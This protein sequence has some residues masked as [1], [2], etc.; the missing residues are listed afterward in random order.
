MFGW[1]K[2]LFGKADDPEIVALVIIEESP[3]LIEVERVRAAFRTARMSVEPVEERP[4]YV[5]VAKSGWN[6]VVL[7][8]PIRYGAFEGAHFKDN[9]MQSLID[10]HQ[11]F[12]CVECF[13]A[14][15]GV[16]RASAAR[17]ILAKVTNA[18]LDDTS[19]ALYEWPTG[20]YAP[21]SAEVREHLE[22]G[23]MQS[24]VDS[25]QALI[26]SVE[27]DAIEG[28]MA[29]ARQRWPEFVAHFQTLDAPSNAL[30]K[31]RFEWQDSAE[32]MWMEPIEVTPAGVRGTLLN[33]PLC[34]WNVKCGDVVWKNLDEVS[35]WGVVING[36]PIGM[37][38]NQIVHGSAERE[39]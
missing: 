2:K 22:A 18:F 17:P 16:D 25:Y 5:R 14:P 1:I 38:T 9:R 26:V 21:I 19:L 33:E 36:Q 23:D 12:F 35:D 6:F 4:N 15:P 11:A 31:C 27:D 32:H 7:S 28:A 24:V 10:R 37:F 30:V 8:Y 3:R 29:E 13:E 34:I 20:R 39:D